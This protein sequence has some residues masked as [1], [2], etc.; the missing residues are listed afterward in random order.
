MSERVV[1]VGGSAGLGA[2]VASAL[3]NS[4]L[5]VVI[6]EEREQRAPDDGLLREDLLREIASGPGVYALREPPVKEE[7][8]T[9]AGDV[10]NRRHPNSARELRRAEKGKR[11]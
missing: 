10:P 2:A 8:Q 3:G 11:R 7:R 6:V 1:I 9:Y 4:G 5:G